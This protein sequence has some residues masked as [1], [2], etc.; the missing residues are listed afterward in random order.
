MST[1]VA[2]VISHFPDAENGF[3]TTTSGAVSSGAATVGLNSTAGYTNGEPVVFVIDPGNSKKQ[4]FTGII[5]TSGNQVTNVV[6]T[7]GSNVSHD[8]GATVVDYATATH[9]AM[10]SKGIKVE[11]NQDGSHDETLITS[12]TAAA[13]AASDS[14]LFS[15]ASDSNALKK[16]TLEDLLPAGV[17]DPEDLTAG[18]GTSWAW[19]TWS[20][21][22][23]GITLGN[24]TLTAKYAQHGKTVR[25]RFHLVV[26]STTSFSGAVVKFTLPVTAIAYGN[27]SNGA[28]P[29]IGLT[30]TEDVGSNAY[31]G[32]VDMDST[33]TA[34]PLIY[35]ASASFTTLNAVTNA[36][37]FTW[38]TGDELS[39]AG[40]Y[41]AA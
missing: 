12:R 14:V 6:W 24:G 21:T 26:G 30:R 27:A 5:D 13:T 39:A 23:T 8:A 25:F 36:V 1:S 16:V 37:P 35:N 10:I 17:V 2:N 19:Q 41:E 33:T 11:H 3:T 9:I 31:A 7:A 22:L 15:D 32:P 20:P 40:A 18:T 38:A 4:T 29:H 28:F 34:R